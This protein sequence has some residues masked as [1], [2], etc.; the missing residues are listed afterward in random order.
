MLDAAALEKIR[1][2]IADVERTTDAELVTVLAARSD[3]YRYVP[4]LW[5]AIVALLVPLALV[6]F[7]LAFP[8]V[9]AAQ[10][11]T[12]CVLAL[13]LHVPDLAMR[14]VPRELK[15]WRAANLARR[16]FLEQ[17]LHH[18]EGDIGVLIF[19]SEAEHY[20][21]IIADRGVSRH[22]DD[23]QWENIVAAFVVDVRAGRIVDGYLRAIAECGKLLSVSV[24]KTPDNRNE[25]DD[26]L[27]MIG[28]DGV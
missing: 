4:V 10:L 15:D 6:P 27:V 8:V 17:E 23:T 25:L 19:V 11:G 7:P 20:V 12:F 1:Q 26:R 28:Y 16:M 5:A 24:P 13:V 22:I 14:L 21:E 18:T 2:A 9:V 3:D